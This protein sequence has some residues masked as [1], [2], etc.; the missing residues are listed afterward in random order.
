MIVVMVI[1]KNMVIVQN[2]IGHSIL[3][4][5]QRLPIAMVIVAHN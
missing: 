4:A 5:T 1:A 2:L 3:E